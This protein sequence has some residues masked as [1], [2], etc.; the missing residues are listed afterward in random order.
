MRLL[1][2]LSFPGDSRVLAFNSERKIRDLR[3]LFDVVIAVENWMLDRQ[4]H[5]LLF[6]KDLLEFPRRLGPFPFAPEI[7]QHQ[8]TAA[9]QIFPERGGFFLAEENPARLYDVN[10]WILF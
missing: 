2:I 4:L 6:G 9:Q 3:F 5:R 1:C 8:K 7:V 10:E